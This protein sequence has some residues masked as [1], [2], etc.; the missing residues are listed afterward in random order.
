MADELRDALQDPAYPGDYPASVAFVLRQLYTGRSLVEGYLYQ[1]VFYADVAHTTA[2]AATK[3]RI[4]VDVPSG[5]A[6]R[7]NGTAYVTVSVSS[8]SDLAAVHYTADD[9]SAA[10]KAQARTNIGAA[11]QADV[12]PMQTNLNRLV[13]KENTWDA[14]QA[15]L[16][17]DLV[18]TT[19]SNNHVRSGGIFSWVTG[20]FTNLTLAWNKITGTPTT[21]SGY[22]ITDAVKQIRF[23]SAAAISP[24]AS[25]VLNV[26]SVSDAG[27]VRFDV[28]QTLNASQRLMAQQNIGVTSTVTVAKAI[29]VADAWSARMS[30]RE[31]TELLTK[32]VNYVKSKEGIA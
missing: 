18:P 10:Q 21:L 14:K 23:G 7:W 6:F 17:Y 22:G 29:A 25:G 8:A 13:G 28:A 2:I 30:D 16:T 5:T 15:A 20:L 11:A 1:G 3:E 19:N 12:S 32:L 26:P 31:K 9:V 4:Y 27:A 24:D